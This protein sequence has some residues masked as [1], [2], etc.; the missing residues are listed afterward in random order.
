MV[1]LPDTFKYGNQV[2][3]LAVQIARCNGSA[4]G[5]DS[6]NIHISN[7][8][9][10]ARHILITASDSHEGIHIVATH[11]CLNRVRNNVA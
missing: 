11:G 1:P 4:V 10:G 8:N 3:V 5:K 2:N 7:G 6:W 9:H